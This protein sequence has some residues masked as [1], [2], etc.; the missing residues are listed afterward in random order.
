MQRWHRDVDQEVGLE[1][2]LY[3]DFISLQ[4]VLG[5]LA[6][7]LGQI[8]KAQARLLAQV[9]NREEAQGRAL[10]ERAAAL[11]GQLANSLDCLLRLANDAGVSLE[12]AYL[13]RMLE[14]PT[15]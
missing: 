13:E 1:C 6:G 8:W 3:Q 11:K 10:Q 9:G 7:E 15:A 14:N 12:E 4:A 2:D 5:N